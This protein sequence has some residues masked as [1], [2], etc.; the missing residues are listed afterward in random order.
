M[1]TVHDSV[2]RPGIDESRLVFSIGWIH[3]FTLIIRTMK[4]NLQA[5]SVFYPSPRL[6]LNFRQSYHASVVW[7]R[8]IKY[9]LSPLGLLCCVHWISKGIFIKGIIAGRWLNRST[10]Y[11]LVNFQSSNRTARI[12]NF[13][14]GALLATIHDYFVHTHLFVI[15]DVQAFVKVS[16]FS[17]KNNVDLFS[18]H[19]L[20]LQFLLET[21]S[22]IDESVFMLFLSHLNSFLRSNMNFLWRHRHHIIKASLLVLFL[23][24]QNLADP[25]TCND[26][27]TTSTDN[28]TNYGGDVCLLRLWLGNCSKA[29]R[30]RRLDLDDNTCALFDLDDLLLAV[31]RLHCDGRIDIHRRKDSAIVAVSHLRLQGHQLGAWGAGRRWVEVAR[32]AEVRRC[33]LRKGRE[34]AAHRAH[35]APLKF[36]ICVLFECNSLLVNRKTV[37]SWIFSKACLRY[38]GREIVSE[39][40]RARRRKVRQAPNLYVFPGCIL[41]IRVFDPVVVIDIKGYSASN[42][43]SVFL[44][45][46]SW[47]QLTPQNT[48]L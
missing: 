47:A 10:H 3:R 4:L 18:S 6:S 37:Q 40:I 23:S 38:K 26:H 24:H 27:Q 43:H 46:Q 15:S 9:V 33:G 30:S 32:L 45:L 42:K 17:F 13:L 34:V 44:N 12:F 41:S 21:L 5:R 16:E 1:S 22:L 48:S 19:T 2:R 7:L 36:E 35:V 25:D 29:D 39:T 20:R 14:E 28:A 31:G 11:F 8:G